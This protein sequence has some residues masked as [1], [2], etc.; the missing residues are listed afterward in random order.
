MLEQ[1]FG[2]EKVCLVA[3]CL[4]AFEKLVLVHSAFL[5][6]RGGPCSS[7]NVGSML[8]HVSGCCNPRGCERFFTPRF[9]RRMARRYRKKGLDKT[10]L[11]MVEFLESRGIEG[12]T[13]LEVGGGVGEIQLELLRRGARHA[14]NLELSPAYE[15]D[16]N[17]LL[18]EA[19][20]QARAERRLHD[21]AVD[22]DGVEPA[23]VVVL[24]RVVCCYPDYEHLLGTAAA[25][26]RRLLVFSYPPRNALSRLFVGAENLVF[27]L[28]GREFRTFAHPPQRML[29]VAA[30]G[31][32]RQA[33]AHRGLVWQ[34]A[35]FE[36]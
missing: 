13:V 16:A 6:T 24:H 21:I 33:L 36:R 1:D 15:R 7:P 30:Q 25:H 22:P 10:A 32:L 35:G 28:L 20:L 11:A 5:H 34:V 12:A 8:S 29:S 19:N 26:A 23:D 18:R 27:R 9:A 2:L 17:A 4:V 3:G 31:G 14:V